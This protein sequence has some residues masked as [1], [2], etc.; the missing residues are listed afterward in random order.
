LSTGWRDWN[1]CLRT[2]VITIHKLPVDSFTFL[3]YLSVTELLN[4]S[5][6]PYTILDPEWKSH[7]FLL[8]GLKSERTHLLQSI[9]S[10]S[11]EKPGRGAE[12]PSTIT[13]S[14]IFSV[15]FFVKKL[16]Q[17]HRICCRIQIRPQRFRGFEFSDDSLLK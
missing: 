11:P 10:V 15:C 4:L 2:M 6:T 12:F 5:G 1:G 14:I 9:L 13:Y 7:G 3:Q 17:S 8:R 16:L